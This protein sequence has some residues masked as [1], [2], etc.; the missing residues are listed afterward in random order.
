[1]ISDLEEEVLFR[2]V[3]SCE[4]GGCEKSANVSGQIIPNYLNNCTESSGGDGHACKAELKGLQSYLTSRPELSSGVITLNE[5]R[6]MEGDQ[7]V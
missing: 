4:Q 2:F 6:D 5:R 3:K 1:V 7:I